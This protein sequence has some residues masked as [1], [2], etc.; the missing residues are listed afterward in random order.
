MVYDNI[1][2]EVDGPMALITINRPEKHNAISLAT[3]DEL[4]AAV[5]EADRDEVVRVITITGTGGRAFASDL[6][7]PK[8]SIATLARRL[9][10]SYK[11]SPI[12][13]SECPSRLSRRSTGFVWEEAL[14]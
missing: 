8:S 14:R 6:I 12:N 1:H 10:P 3:L 4:Q 5:R 9:S 7:S 11:D 2:Y 13:W